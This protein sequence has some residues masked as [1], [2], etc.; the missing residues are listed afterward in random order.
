MILAKGTFE[1]A[2]AALKAGYSVK[3]TGWN[4]QDQFVFLVNEP[5]L[6]ADQRLEVHLGTDSVELQSMLMIRTAD[7]KLVSWVPSQ[8]DVLADDWDLA[9]YKMATGKDESHG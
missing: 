3:R 8:S 5:T 4:S 1:Q 6:Q 7:K 9:G 2:L